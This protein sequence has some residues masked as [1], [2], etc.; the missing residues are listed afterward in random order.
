MDDCG[1]TKSVRRRF[2]KPGAG[3][4]DYGSLDPRGPDTPY[5]YITIEWEGTRDLF[6][7][8]LVSFNTKIFSD[9]SERAE[10]FSLDD[11]S[12]FD[13]ATYTELVDECTSFYTLGTYT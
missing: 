3:S 10:T 1:V 13:C 7:H 8:G 6:K 12:L 5:P 2:N 4:T 9:C 11:S